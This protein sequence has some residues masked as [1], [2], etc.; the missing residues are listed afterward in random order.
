MGLVQHGAA[1]L[2]MLILSVSIASV[3]RGLATVLKFPN[4]FG[5]MSA[6]V[7]TVVEFLRPV[8]V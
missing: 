6:K 2:E 1:G 4:V 7:K 3:P 5:T 8:M